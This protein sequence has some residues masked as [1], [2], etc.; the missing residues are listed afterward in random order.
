[1]RKFIRLLIFVFV[2]GQFLHPG[3]LRAQHDIGNARN[4]NSSNEGLNINHDTYSNI[5][6]V[7]KDWSGSH[8]ILFNAYKSSSQVNGG[9]GTTGNTKFTKDV[10][11][12]STGAG[13]IMFYG[14]GGAMDFLISGY[15]SGIDTNVEWGATKMRIL[16]N[17]NIGIGTTTPTE[18]LSV[19]GTIRSKEV[20]VESTPWPDYVFTDTY[21]LNSLSEVSTFISENGHLP[22]I[23]TAK[24]VKENGIKLGEMNAKLLEKIEELTLYLIEQTNR[25]DALQDEVMLLK[26]ANDSSRTKKRNHSSK[27]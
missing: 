17:G 13:A 24:E 27:K 15:S 1:M 21:K 26:G 12:Y 19:N 8:G 18:K 23:P 6:M 20:L 22:N 25:I 5:Q 11:A 16:R 10:G 7:T 2:V 9:L 4:V 3:I 14:N